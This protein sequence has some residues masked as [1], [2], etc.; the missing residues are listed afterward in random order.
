MRRRPI[1]ELLTRNN[2]EPEQPAVKLLKFQPQPRPAMPF[3]TPD[4]QRL[5]TAIVELYRV[6]PTAAFC[7]E[8]LIKSFLEKAI[9][10]AR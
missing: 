5:A 2:D 9:G 3:Q 1:P 7:A 4:E 6:W 8:R 10:G